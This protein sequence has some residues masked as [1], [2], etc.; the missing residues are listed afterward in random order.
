MEFI[1][2]ELGWRPPG[3]LASLSAQYTI[4]VNLWA[5]HAR[6]LAGEDVPA[7][8]PG[9]ESVFGFACLPVKPGARNGVSRADIEEFPGV[10][11]I[12]MRVGLGDTMGEIISSTAGVAM[13]LFEAPDMDSCEDLIN[14][15]VQQT[16]RLHD[17]KSLRLTAG[18]PRFSRAAACPPPRSA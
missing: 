14:S 1:A 18:L 5:A 15:A 2:G 7:E 3:I 16:Y 11:H 4:G 10:R 8:H 6:L 12:Q 13:V 17:D 9:S